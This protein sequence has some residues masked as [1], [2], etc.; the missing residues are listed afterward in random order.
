L[1]FTA[2]SDLMND[3]NTHN[4]LF[5]D[6]KTRTDGAVFYLS[7]FQLEEK[8]HA[9]AY[10]VGSRNNSYYDESGYN[11][12]GTQNQID[13]TSNSNNGSYCASF[14]GTYSYIELPN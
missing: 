4:R 2:G 12:D 5:F 11:N 8:D 1:T 6:D 14:N 7:N 9:T 10:I 13:Y 3:I